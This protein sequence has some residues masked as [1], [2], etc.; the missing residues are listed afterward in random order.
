MQTAG[1]LSARAPR[2][3]PGTLLSVPLFAFAPSE[4][5]L[6]GAPLTVAATILYSWAPPRL[7]PARCGPAAA[8]V[9][10]ELESKELLAT[11]VA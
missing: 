4:L 3:A 11:V 2:A 5:F 9:E 7:L 1:C 6:L 8:P 10:R